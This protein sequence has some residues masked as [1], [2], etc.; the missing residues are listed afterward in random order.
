MLSKLLPPNSISLSLLAAQSGIPTSTL[1]TWKSKAFKVTNNNG[2]SKKKLTAKDK[3]NFVLESYK[4]TEF[5]LSKF[6][7]KNGLYVGEVKKWRSNFEDSLEKG[8]DNIKEV[9]EE[10]LKTKKKNTELEKEL[11]RKEK[12]LAEA[13]TLLVLQ[14]KFQ[15]FMEEEGN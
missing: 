12:A 3:L 6:C 2:T 4:L 10:L 8:T 1:Y 7:R 5:E 13:A 9:K 14:K 11:K 15:A